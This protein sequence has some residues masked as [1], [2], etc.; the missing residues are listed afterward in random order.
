MLTPRVLRERASAVPGSLEM[1]SL[2]AEVLYARRVVAD[3]NRDL[4]RGVGPRRAR[5][6][7]RWAWLLEGAARWFAGQ[8]DYSRPAIARRLREGKRPSFPPDLSD[9]LL[10]G[11]TVIDLLA[12][13]HGEAAAAALATRLDPHGPRRALQ[14]AFGG[15]P[16]VHIEGAWRS[17]L[18]AM[19]TRS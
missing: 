7:L 3:S 5:I 19:A 13:E 11:G 9:A 17:H 18:S 8:T 14:R 4:P 6:E 2:T 1:L 16:L 10:L 15:A 12:R